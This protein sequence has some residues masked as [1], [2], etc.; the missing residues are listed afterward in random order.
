LTCPV[1]RFRIWIR[2]P[3]T[4]RVAESETCSRTVPSSAAVVSACCRGIRRGGPVSWDCC[5]EEAGGELAGCCDIA[6]LP[7]A[8]PS[9]AHTTTRAKAANPDFGDVPALIFQQDQATRWTTVSA[10]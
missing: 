10:N 6:W 7:A 8:S 2:A 5:S 3:T 9:T 4:G 1:C